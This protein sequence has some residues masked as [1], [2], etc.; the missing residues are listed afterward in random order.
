MSRGFRYSASNKG[1]RTL[2]PGA[3]GSY[4]AVTSDFFIYEA[5]QV[6]EVV[7]NEQSR[8][9]DSNNK[10]ATSNTGRIKVRFV[11]GD[12]DTGGDIARSIQSAVGLPKSVTEQLN[13][14]WADPLTPHQTIYP[15]IGE[16]VLV[17][18]MLGTYW[19]IGPINTKRKVTENAYPI[20]N[21]SE[22]QQRDLRTTITRR[23]LSG[24]TSILNPN[25]NKVAGLK[26]EE[27]SVNPLKQ[28]EG[29]VIYQ[30]RYGN[31]I[32]LG[33]SLMTPA[34]N[35]EQYPNILMRV[36][37]TATPVVTTDDRGGASLTVENLDTDA[38]SI[39]LTS[40]QVIQ[41]SPATISSN[42]H[43]FSVFNKPTFDGAQIIINSDKVFINSKETSIYLFARKGVHINALDDG[44][45]IDSG[46]S[47]LL[48]TP[49]NMELFSEKSLEIKGKEDITVSTTRDVNI[50]GDRNITVYGNEI[51]LGGRSSQ[52]SPMVLGKPLKMFLYE[53][54]RVMMSN[55]AMIGA[56]APNPAYIARLLLLFTKYQVLPDP[57]NPLFNSNDNFVMKTNEATMK[58]DLPPNRGYKFTTGLGNTT[59]RQA[60]SFG[61]SLSREFNLP[62]L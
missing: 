17:F 2:Q 22:N 12:A 58:G 5:A 56:G 27:L 44:V 45:T 50:S 35:E 29:D 30:G 46:G 60:V 42:I 18:K 62:R 48:R 21:N 25:Q 20:R 31:S 41:F 55:P 19:Y 13:D 16:Y 51:F 28:Y 61:D 23:A 7:N 24:V 3:P 10:S 6:I 47:I 39:Y 11:S 34:S 36:G 59:Q 9:N 38:S 49:K 37:Q 57:F 4:G 14:T 40:K 26:F 32:R 8:M 43:L 33:S 53:M 15:L 1:V 52:A 54:L